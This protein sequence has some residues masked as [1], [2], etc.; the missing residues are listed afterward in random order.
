MGTNKEFR[1]Y[2]M[3][4]FLSQTKEL[5]YSQYYND[6]E[7]YFCIKRETKNENE[8]LKEWF[9]IYHDD[10][11]KLYYYDFKSKRGV[12][13]KGA[14][15]DQ[16]TS[17][18]TTKFYLTNG[19]EQDPQNFQETFINELKFDLIS[20]QTISFIGDNNNIPTDILKPYYIK[21]N[22]IS[23][24]NN[25]YLLI[26]GKK[27]DINNKIEG[28]FHFSM[29][30]YYIKLTSIKGQFDAAYKSDSEI[31]LD[32]FKCNIIYNNFQTIP[33]NR[34]IL[35]EFKNGKNGEKKMFKQVIDY[36]R[37]ANFLF[38]NEEAFFL[39]II[40]KTI[41]LGNSLKSILV[42]QKIKVKLIVWG[43]LQY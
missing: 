17:P 24:G 11:S 43:I 16:K 18:E 22:L 40:I 9:L 21:G 41:D 42:I 23:T 5:I 29:K 1:F 26:F 37:N 14:K 27:K 4:L 20:S 7:D 31:T 34:I 15:E 39:I 28:K 8:I 13:V 38:E 3:D 6:W 30:N 19:E 35:F 25:P 33:K 2:Q 32:E 12:I 36:Q 10:L